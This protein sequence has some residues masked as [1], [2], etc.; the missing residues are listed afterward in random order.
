MPHDPPSLRVSGLYYYP[1]K[2]AAGI[3]LTCAVVDAFGIAGDRRFMLVDDTGRF[4]SQ[5]DL[6]RLALVG[7]SATKGR[8]E[9]S[10]PG[11]RPLQVACV[12]GW[13]ERFQVTIWGDA[14]EALAAPPDINAWFRK[15]LGRE[16]LRLVWSEPTLDRQVDLE[17]ASPGDRVAFADGFPF[18]LTT[19]GSLRDL[20]A[21]LSHPV[22]MERFRPNVVLSGAPAYA[23]DRWER[24]RIGALPF[25]VVKPC[26]RCQIPN[27]VQATATLEKEPLRTLSSY[28]KRDGHVL[29]GQNMVHEGSGVLTLG[30]AA[31]VY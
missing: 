10:F 18:L 16:D 23:E 26:A 29:F 6:H 25:R 9:F 3:A 28:R 7:V 21:R 11:Q 17:Y 4:V 24:L 5:R 30:D 1:L 2:S 19:D 22:P 8:L 15:A 20:N 13:R 31:H 27:I 12:P 14:C